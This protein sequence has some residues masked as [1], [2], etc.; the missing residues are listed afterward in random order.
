[1]RQRFAVLSG[2]IPFEDQ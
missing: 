2:C 1:M